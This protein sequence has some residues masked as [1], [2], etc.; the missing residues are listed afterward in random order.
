MEIWTYS[1]PPSPPSPPPAVPWSFFHNE[2]LTHMGLDT[3]VFNVKCYDPSRDGR[4]TGT[5]HRLCKYHGPILVLL[6]LN[7]N[8]VLGG[9]LSKELTDNPQ[10]DDYGNQVGYSNKN[11]WISDSNAFIWSMPPAG[12]LG[13]AIKMTVRSAGNAFKE[14]PAGG[15]H[16]TEAARRMI[17]RRRPCA[18][19]RA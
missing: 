18:D 7:N 16:L 19:L 10:M 11:S 6:E 8:K 15:T 5:W 1:H 2:R 4:S 9:Y 14:Y 3:S 12:V 13:S 17:R